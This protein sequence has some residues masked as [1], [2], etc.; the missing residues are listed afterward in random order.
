M[1]RLAR[2]S[3]VAVALGVC[4]ADAWS[5]QADPSAPSQPRTEDLFVFKGGVLK[6][7]TTRINNDPTIYTETPGFIH[8]RN[9]AIEKTVP[10]GLTD[11]FLVEFSAE[12]QL[13]GGPGR[14]DWLELEVRVND[15]PIQPVGHFED[16]LAFCGDDNYGSYSK[17]FATDRLPAGRYLFKVYVKIVDNGTDQNL[18]A[19]LDDWT[20]QVITAD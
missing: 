8:V 2:I 6:D 3:L 16:P 5:Q 7:V 14:F 1:K 4:G 10:G 19:W 17:Q 13:R 20:F 9:A 11:S 18:T 12:C 15:V